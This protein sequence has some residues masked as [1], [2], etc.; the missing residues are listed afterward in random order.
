M[1]TAVGE[2]DAES[3]AT[4]PTLKMGEEAFECCMPSPLRLCTTTLHARVIAT[5]DVAEAEQAR[6]F[7]VL[8][9]LV[10]ETHFNS[11]TTSHS[12]HCCRCPC[13]QQASSP[14]N[15]LAAFALFTLFRW[16]LGNALSFSPLARRLRQLVMLLPLSPLLPFRSRMN[17]TINSLINFFFFCI[18]FSMFN[19]YRIRRLPSC[20]GSTC[21]CTFK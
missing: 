16:W 18:V 9:L 15:T 12:L 13:E 4:L 3:T 2:G 7:V 19:K 21:R 11:P 6:S 17:L 5:Y 10:L 1:S 20:N 8:S 14:T